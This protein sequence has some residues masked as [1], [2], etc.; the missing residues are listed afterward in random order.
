[1]WPKVTGAGR[2]TE[3]ENVK[4]EKKTKIKCKEKA[5]VSKRQ[6]VSYIAC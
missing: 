3:N 5:K 6:Y 1:M 2:T 4:N